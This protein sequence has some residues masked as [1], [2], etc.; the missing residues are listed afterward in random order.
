MK[1]FYAAALL[2]ALGLSSCSKDYT[3]TCTAKVTDSGGT[4]VTQNT[5]AR[6]LNGT[7]GKVEDECSASNA[8][9][10][11]GGFTTTITCEAAG[12]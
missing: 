3:C 4:V 11:A 9:S 8:T 12:Q 6:V 7:K 1:V 5:T 2:L 10:S